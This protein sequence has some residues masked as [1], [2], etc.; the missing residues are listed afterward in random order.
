MHMMISVTGRVSLASF[1]LSWAVFFGGAASTLAQ[2]PP[3]AVVKPGPGI[4]LPVVVSEVKPS[5]PADAMA[6]GAEGSVELE[7][8]VNTDGSVGDV[9]VVRPLYPLLDEAALAAIKQWRFKPGLR[10]GQPVPV[11]VTVEM[12]FTFANGSGPRL[13]SPGVFKPGPDVTAPRLLSEVKPVYTPAAKQAG[14]EGVVVIECVVLADGAVGRIRVT[15]SLTPELDV[16]AVKALKK[17]RFL[18]GR[19][20]GEAVPVQVVAELAF[21]L[22]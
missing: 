20:A 5:Y 10:E 21:A 7:C 6:V 12:T 14:I 8:V 18:P 16:E 15:K 11:L 13:D 22:Q 19:R 9:R 3:A 4:T 1:L 2:T 17:W